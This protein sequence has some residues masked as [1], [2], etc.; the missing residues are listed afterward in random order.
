[1]VSNY[2]QKYFS[3]LDDSPMD[4]SKEGLDFLQSISTTKLQGGHQSSSDLFYI[5][6]HKTE[7]K[8]L[9]KILDSFFEQV[10]PLSLN[11]ASG[12]YLGYIPGGGIFLS[13]L[14]DFLALA[15]N[16]YA[17]VNF[18]A[19]L[20]SQ[21]EVTIIKWLGSL[22][23]YDQKTCGGVLTSG[24]SMA[25]LT[26]LIVARDHKLK[27]DDFFRGVL[28][29]SEQTHLSI[30]KA[31]HAAGIKTCNVKKIRLNSNYQIDTDDLERQIQADVAKGLAPFL[32]IA[33]AGTTDCGAVDDLHAISKITQ[34]YQ[35]WFHTDAAYGGFFILTERGRKVL[36]DME[37]S[38]SITLDPHKGLFLPY[39]TGALIV[40]DDQHLQNSFTL[41]A[42][43]IS[44]SVDEEEFWDF[45]HRSL[46]MSRA[47]RGLRILLPLQYYSTKTFKD[48]LNEKLDLAEWIYN[49]LSND[50]RF[51]VLS[52]PKLSLLAFRLTNLASTSE[53][54]HGNQMTK[55][56]LELINSK[57][58]VFVSG[59]TIEGHFYIRLAIL[60]YRT[61]QKHLE[62]F[63]S[64]LVDSYEEILHPT[65]YTSRSATS[66]NLSIPG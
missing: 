23:G 49:K 14:A 24:G 11:T 52:V 40:K 1:M 2:L 65:S 15:T 34:K 45:S 56:L 43:Y 59:T 57:Q 62:M 10:V 44:Q 29:G 30:W 58:R 9:P 31:A 28:Y 16:R 47:A 13:A 8:S 27:D 63:W 46:E 25:N 41:K 66:K 64:D 53:Q 7:S 60:S 48:L 39:G 17:G 32:V 4:L 36:Q 6:T 20:L 33:N 42:H 50:Q 61:H 19:P 22:V 3:S 55:L 26:A 51:H 35:L 5:P 21:M 54:E 12:G 18:T 38:D 37:L